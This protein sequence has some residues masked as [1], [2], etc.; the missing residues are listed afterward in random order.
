MS[1]PCGQ[2]GRVE[3][4]GALPGSQKDHHVDVIALGQLTQERLSDPSDSVIPIIEHTSIDPEAK[5]AASHA[6]AELLN[7]AKVTPWELA[8]LLKRTHMTNRSLYFV[9]F[10][11]IL[12]SAAESV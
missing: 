8:R 5:L 1:Q 7:W 11:A 6:W 12:A 10:C 2:R 3:S 4:L 9:T